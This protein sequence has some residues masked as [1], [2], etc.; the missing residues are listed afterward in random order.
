[1]GTVRHLK[2]QLKRSEQE[3]KSK[4]YTSRAQ[5]RLY[6]TVNWDEADNKPEVKV[7]KNTE[8]WKY[9]KKKETGIYKQN[10]QPE[11]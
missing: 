11:R 3:D 1:M 10:I 5:K 7:K 8:G 2:R 9:T 6:R 4:Q